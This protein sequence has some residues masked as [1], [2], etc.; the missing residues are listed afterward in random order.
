MSGQ[1]SYVERLARRAGG[2]VQAL[3]AGIDPSPD[4]TALLASP[5]PAGSRGAVVDHARRAAGS[6]RRPTR[7]AAMERFSGMVIEAVRDHAV[8]VKLQVAW[9]EGAGAPGLRALERAVEYAR[10]AGLLVVLDAKRGDVPHSA[11]AYADAWLGDEA[12]SGICGDALTVNAAVGGDLL[13]VMAEVAAQRRCALYALLHTSNPGAAALQSVPTGPDDRPWWELLA[14]TF[15]QVD[16]SVGPGVVG[17]VV[18]ATRPELVERARVLL[19]RAPLLLPGVGAQGGAAPK[20]RIDAAAPVELVA[21]SRSLL[22]TQPVATAGFRSA[23]S[24]A[25]A[26]FSALLAASGTTLLQS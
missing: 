16:A 13:L 23:V 24:T 18:G 12:S 4:A 11:R 8:A 2:A 19:P 22:P 1:T 5:A 10:R 7:A 17:A 15:A 21:A 25:A 20:A 9:F 3:C 14:D 6:D 26:E